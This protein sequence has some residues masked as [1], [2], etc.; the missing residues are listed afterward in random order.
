MTAKSSKCIVEVLFKNTSL[1]N[2]NLS[3]NEFDK[4]CV[5]ALAE[6]MQRNRTLVRLNL[7]NAVF[8]KRVL[9][10]QLDGWEIIMYCNH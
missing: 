5:V 8:K 4:S 1:K 9:L 10:P 2:L 6:S 7:R 3:G